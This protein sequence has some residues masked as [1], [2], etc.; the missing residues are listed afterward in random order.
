[1]VRLEGQWI[2]QAGVLEANKVSGP[3]VFQGKK[4]DD[5]FSLIELYNV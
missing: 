1:M 2:L 5:L 3:Q 4:G